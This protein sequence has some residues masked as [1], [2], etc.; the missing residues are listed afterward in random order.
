MLSLL[1]LNS[2]E[3]SHICLRNGSPY[4]FHSISG[5]DENLGKLEVNMITYDGFKVHATAQCEFH[6]I[7]YGRM[8]GL[9]Q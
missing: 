4:I 8:S 7:N 1:G 5:D 2:N 9:Q 6:D 3:M